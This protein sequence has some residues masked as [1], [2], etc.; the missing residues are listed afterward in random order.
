MFLL[1]I[2]S[3]RK[4]SGCLA[5]TLCKM[6]TELT[7]CEKNPK[8]V[9]IGKQVTLDDAPVDVAKPEDPT[10][11]SPMFQKRSPLK[12]KKGMQISFNDTPTTS[13]ADM[14]AEAGK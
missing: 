10:G 5:G 2:D 7:G 8:V 9:R 1:K 4:I 13:D 14:F 6:A 12:P 3:G 11:V